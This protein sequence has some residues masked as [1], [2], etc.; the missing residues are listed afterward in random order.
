LVGRVVRS[1]DGRYGLVVDVGREPNLGHL[2][3]ETKKERPE[4]HEPLVA[5]LPTPAP[6]GHALTV[7]G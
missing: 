7:V 4:S 3:P 5:W 6:Y 2:D 1:E